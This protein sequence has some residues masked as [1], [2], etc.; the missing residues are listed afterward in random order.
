MDDNN[1]IAKWELR[2]SEVLFAGSSDK[3]AL[4]IEFYYFQF[5]SLINTC[6]LILFEVRSGI[7]SQMGWNLYNT[8]Q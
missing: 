7:K 6:E 4:G 5:V 2:Y 1:F 3:N 8:E